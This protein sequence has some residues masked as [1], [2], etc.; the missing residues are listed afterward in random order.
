MRW[1]E[2]LNPEQLRAVRHVD[3]PLLVIAGAGSGKTRIITYRVVHLLELGVPPE[4]ILAV[5]FTNKAAGEM[6]ER[7]ASLAHA[8][9]LTCTFHG[10][11]A[12]IL[13][14]SIDALGF[15]KDFVIFDEEDS[16]KVL[17]S[18]AVSLGLK[19]DKG[20]LKAI[21]SEIS[22]AK[23]NAILPERFRGETPHSAPLYQ[24]YQQRLQEY[25][26][27]DFDDLLYL[28]V[29]LFTERPD[30][31]EHYQNLWAF[32]LIDE[33]QDTNAS[34]YEIIRQL[35]ARHHNVCAVG[36]PDQSIYSWRGANIGNILN[37]ERDYPG[38]AVISLEQN[39]RSR[40]TILQ[41]AN[42]LIRH[43]AGRYEKR[44]WSE[45][46]TGDKIGVFVAYSERGETEFVLERILH[47]HERERIPLR[48]CVIFYRT[49]FQSRA[50]E[51]ALLRH[52]IPYVIIGGLSFYQRK[53]VK[54]VIALL[55]VVLAGGD[56]LSFSRTVNLPK[57]GLGEACL[58]KLRQRAEEASLDLFTTCCRIAE[59][60]LTHTL[61]AKQLAGL[62]EY[63]GAVCA[64]REMVRARR[65]L[66][67]LISSAIERMRYLE[68]LK[69]EEP[70]T[71]EE[72]R[73]NLS[74]LVSKAAEWEEEA[75]E[76]SLT[77]FLEE[78]SLKADREEQDAAHD[79]LQL[80]TL[81]N[82]KGLEFAVVCLVGME[83]DLLP[84]VNAKDNPEALEEERR[85]CYVGMTRAK[86]HLYLTA[87]RARF[88]WGT[89]RMMRPSRF[90]NE[91]P[92][93][94]LVMHGTLGAHAGQ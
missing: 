31:L 45:R 19:E 76:P 2:E 64:L 91:I 81:H 16:D 8:R 11:C 35:V 1:E 27:L 12:R 90:L 55:R 93:E 21:R 83:E 84:H 47:H 44:L 4:A 34:Q 49:N 38:S 25:N 80:M 82:G 29:R 73:E 5:T 6:R 51:D 77:A 94:H 43:N 66:H 59:G 14:A 3:G 65:P 7:I 46:G 58:L 23:N 89:P 87:S 56:Y 92:K 54:D 33:Y 20:S 30:V 9:I 17:K 57:R 40:N 72:R 63:T 74:E 61:S 75:E 52:R 85:L 68:H 48:E 86:E 62:R 69:E 15:R 18:C 37:F 50:F 28:T 41:A 88:L 13:R 26:A 24:L 22:R 10:L 67:E 42:A 53:E 32:V 71:Y 78:L 79:S 39:Y 60:A 70:D 36:D